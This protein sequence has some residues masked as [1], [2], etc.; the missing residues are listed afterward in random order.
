M[1][2]PKT[3]EVTLLTWTADPL[4]TVY[5]VWMASKGTG[6]L[7]T[8][9]EVKA[10]VD[11]AEVRKLF[12]A[13]I[14]QHI[15]IGE[16]LDFVFMFSNISVS[17]REQA[18]RHRIGTL[19]SPERVGSDFTFNVLPD[20]AG[21]S[22]WSQCFTGDTRVKLL[23]GTS[24]S[25]KEMSEKGGGFWVY[26]V[27]SRGMI[28]P[29]KA[30][31]ARFTGRKKLVEVLLDNGESVRCTLDHLWMKRNGEYCE[32]Q[33]LVA[34]DSLMPLYTRVDEYGYEQ[35]QN[36]VTNRY[37]YTHKVVD[38]YLNG[39]LPAG[40]VVHHTSFDKLN[41]SPRWLERMTEQDHLDL[42]TT[43]VVERMKL[44]P[45][46]H[47]RALSVGQKKHWESLSELERSKKR[48]RLASA[49]LA[50]DIDARNSSA[51]KLMNERWADPEWRA[52]MLPI[53]TGH[54]GRKH[55]DETKSRLSEIA[56][57]R[58]SNHCVVSAR[59]LDVEEDVY[60]I[61]VDEHHNFALASGVFVHNSMRLEDMSHFADNGQYRLPDSI[62]NHSDARMPALYRNAMTMIQ[63]C[64]AELVKGGIPMEDARELVPL[65]AQHRMSWK[66]NISSL[67]HIVGKRSCFILQ[68]GLWGDIIMG[69][70]KELSEKVDPIFAELV[71][72]PCIH[73]DKFKGCVYEEENR[74][75][76][77]GD[78]KHPVCPLHFTQ[79]HVSEQ[80]KQSAHLPETQAK[81]HLP[82]ANE[83]RARA[84]QYRTFWKRDPYTS[85]R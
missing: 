36:L 50:I 45:E 2:D 68:L 7:M 21:S 25:L 41:N 15:P 83:M 40:H 65:G 80:D 59:L 79:H 16:H 39:E 60:D 78:D 62:K 27:D 85:K 44:D 42:H 12:R 38:E 13:V 1:T 29:G 58:L 77:T 67:Q 6:P 24:P 43:L 9:A 20:L 11:P 31:S 81:Y 75:R 63:T 64:Y 33:N 34:G 74:R 76:Y 61:S 57:T 69:M 56:K 28:V 22:W 30:H 18:V 17:W 72:P 48:C 70:M 46:A 54:G 51:K 73:D 10:K 52:K 8:P 14:K 37:E 5:S 47:S 3:P 26:S 84:E 55:S 32:A 66:L 35:I 71:T 49:R 23:D 53:L 19:A 4:E 82:M